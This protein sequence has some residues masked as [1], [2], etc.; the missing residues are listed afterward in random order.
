M[1]VT[2]PAS[3]ANLGPGFDCLGLAID[4]PFHLDVGEPRTEH[5]HPLGA[6]HP[7]AVAFAAEGGEGSLFAESSIAPGTGMGYSGAA[8]VAGLAAAH[9]QRSGSLNFSAVLA[10]A[11]ELEG[12]ADNVAASLYGGVTV[13][14]AGRV[15]RLAPPDLSVVLWIPAGETSTDAARG[16]L[17]PTVGFD[18]AVHNIGRVALL[19]AAL[20]TG[21]HTALA[22]ACE[23]RLHQQW[24]LQAAPGSAA[25]LDAALTNGALAAWLSGS[26]PAVA[27]LSRPSQAERI[28]GALP[29]GGHTKVVGTTRFGVRVS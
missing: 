2:V 10:A 6:A 29:D 1:R 7:A 4:I 19:V 26:G 5:S 11:T 8:R 14:A 3:S 21:D 15:L 28:A 23:D 13:A 17:P 18:D 16:S 9:I 27:A 12:H 20:A 22:A 25:A 24:R